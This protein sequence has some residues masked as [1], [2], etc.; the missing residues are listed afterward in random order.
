MKKYSSLVFF[1][2]LFVWFSDVCPMRGAE[3]RDQGGET[4]PKREVERERERGN[5]RRAVRVRAG[6]HASISAQYQ[7]IATFTFTHI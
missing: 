7:T 1:Q 5:E 3:R 4:E 2:S 6:G